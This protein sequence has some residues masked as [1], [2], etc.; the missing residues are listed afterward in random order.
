MTG[1]L[2]LSVVATWV[3]LCRW[4]SKVIVR[5]AFPHCPQRRAIELSV[6]LVLL[7]LILLDELTAIPEF[8]RACRNSA[9]LV[10][11]RGAQ[12]GAIVWFGSGES[13]PRSFGLLAGSVQRWQYVVAGTTT[14]A[15]HYHVVSARGGF[16]IRT[17]GISATN[18]PLIFDS[19]CAPPEIAELRQWIKVHG[20]REIARPIIK[21]SK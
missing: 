2:L 5:R 4:L 20:M 15:F 13:Q 19:P 9:V 1:L 7:P 6:F 3:A 14:P 17:L 11:E 21:G 10:I 16:F 18:S 12:S 8:R